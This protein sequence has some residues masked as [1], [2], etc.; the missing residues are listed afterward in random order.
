MVIALFGW[1]GSTTVLTQEWFPDI[2]HYLKTWLPPHFGMAV[3]GWYFLLSQNEYVVGFL[4]FQCQTVKL[5]FE[6]IRRMRQSIIIPWI[7]LLMCIFDNSPPIPYTKWYN[8]SIL[9]RML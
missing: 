8:Y 9:E 3:S 4:G 1:I 7:R 5:L 6:C 2:A